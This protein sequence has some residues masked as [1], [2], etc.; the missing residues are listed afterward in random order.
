MNRLT[1]RLVILIFLGIFSTALIVSCGQKAQEADSTASE[2]P[3]DST[4]HPTD[5]TEHPT[6]HPADSTKSN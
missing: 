5:S 2:L 3:A 1:K 4:E 6:E